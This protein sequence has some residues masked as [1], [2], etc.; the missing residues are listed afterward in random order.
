MTPTCI[1]CGASSP[2]R[3]D[4][5]DRN[6]QVSAERFP[7]AV[8]PS[9]G[10]WFLTAV[11]EDLSRYYEASYYRTPAADELAAAARRE[12]YQVE[13]LLRAVQ[14]PGRVVEIGAA[15]GVFASQA[16][17][18]GFDVHAV[19]MDAR[20]CD[21]LRSTVRVDA[22]CS[23]RPELVL[24][25]LPPSRA[26]VMWQVLE[27]LTDPLAVLDAAATNLEA[28]GVLLAATPNPDSLGMRVLGERWPHLDAPRHV[29][30]IPPD[31]LRRWAADRGLR[32][33]FIVD[34][35]LGAR[36]WNRFAWQRLMLNRVRSRAALGPLLAAGAVLSAAVSPWERRPGCGSSYTAA[37]RKVAS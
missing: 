15:W 25:D 24:S 7:Y 30:L 11:P 18:A 21:Y 27:H 31:L 29:T 16:R 35:D 34:T 10:L 4:A 28:G 14:P 12:R 17:D 33:V 37:F 19:E 32:E 23:N 20:C 9:C 8:C 2:I 3:L 36:R 13:L 22:T 26:V 6:R 1:A 5:T